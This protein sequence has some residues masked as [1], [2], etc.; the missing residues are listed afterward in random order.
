[1]SQNVDRRTHSADPVGSP[2]G[3]QHQLRRKLPGKNRRVER[4]EKPGT[5]ENKWLVLKSEGEWVAVRNDYQGTA[6][7]CELLETNKV[8]NEY[9]YDPIDAHAAAA[10]ANAG[11]FGA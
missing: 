1:M 2:C 8:L 5:R 3:P 7:W 6:Y 9:F 10:L 4:L 11:C